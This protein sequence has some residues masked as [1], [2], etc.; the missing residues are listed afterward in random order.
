[1]ATIYYIFLPLQTIYDILREEY[2]IISITILAFFVYLYFRIVLKNKEI[3][4]YLPNL[5]NI[6]LK[7]TVGLFIVF[8][9]VDYYYE[10]GFIG[11]ISQ[12]FIYWIFGLLAYF[13]T[14]IINLFKNYKNYSIQ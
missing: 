8:Q 13:V 14:H 9:I 5:H 12:W 6:S 4:E 2:I 1:M 10:D 11:M 3:F 7:Q